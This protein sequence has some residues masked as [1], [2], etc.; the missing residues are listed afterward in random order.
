[1]ISV[2]LKGFTLVELIMT[3]AIIGLLATVTLPLAELSVQH[4]K[5]QD[6]RLAL[7]EI[8]EG[9]DAYKQAVD[10][11]RII[12]SAEK[13]AY[14]E[15]LQALVDGVP[16]A[17]DPT[18]KNKIYFLRRI[19]RDPMASN[20]SLSDS[21]TWGKRSYESPADDPQE[22][23]NVFDVYSLSQGTGLNGIPYK[24]W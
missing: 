10:D 9:L 3:V 13:S 22:G 23:D 2:R 6:L 14:P 8:R 17:K 4:S 12:H 11:G 16:D 7:R 19:P 21:D 1:M 24:N 5:E 15:S 18:N 20:S